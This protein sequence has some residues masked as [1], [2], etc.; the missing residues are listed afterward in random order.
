MHQIQQPKLA[1]YFS[2]VALLLGS[3]FLA[4]CASVVRTDVNSFLTPDFST[5]GTSIAVV[6]S[7]PQFENS[8]EFK[9]YQFKLEEKLRQQGFVVNTSKG[10]A[11]Y[12]A[13]LGYHIND[14][15]T[16]VESYPVSGHTGFDPVFYTTVVRNK[17]GSSSYVRSAHW[18]P[19]YGIVGSQTRSYTNFTTLITIDIVDQQQVV[20]DKATKVYE[21][22]AR[23]EGSC[24]VVSRIFDEMLAA[25][26]SNFPGENNRVER[27]SVKANMDCY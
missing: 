1:C 4:G 13:K 27:I 9:H 18:V 12:L 16:K 25:I 7:D 22:K 15:E 2:V 11:R 19:T 17:D 24:G 10:D 20:D 6:P 3:L 14:G 8:L 21:V 5:Q 26:F 23:S